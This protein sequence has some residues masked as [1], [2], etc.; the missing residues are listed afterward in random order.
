MAMMPRVWRSWCGPAGIAKC[1]SRAARPCWLLGAPTQ[2]L[3]IVTDLSNQIRGLLKTFGLVV[4]KGA[5]KVFEAK[6]RC[7]LEDEK[8]VAV[9]VKLLSK[10]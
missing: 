2:L 7:L 10:N 6:V 9:I 8:A 4:P 3:G 1:G 5:G